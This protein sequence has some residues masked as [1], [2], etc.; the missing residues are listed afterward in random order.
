MH[1]QFPDNPSIMNVFHSGNYQPIILY[2]YPFLFRTVWVV[3]YGPHLSTTSKSKSFFSLFNRHLAIKHE[4]IMG[5]YK[6]VTHVKHVEVVV[7]HGNIMIK[8][9][10][11]MQKLG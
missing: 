2:F 10:D 9:D 4:N 5:K 6:E 11:I 1:Q 8:Y 3:Q 7:Q